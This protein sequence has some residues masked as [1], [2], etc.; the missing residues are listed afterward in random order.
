MLYHHG[1]EMGNGIS[2]KMVQ[3]AAATLGVPVESVYNAETTTS[4]VNN[5]G[6][7][8]ASVTTDVAGPAVLDACQQLRDRLAPIREKLGASATFAQVAEA[9]FEHRIDLTAHGYSKPYDLWF[10]WE[11]GEGVPLAYFVSAAACVSVEIDTLTGAHSVL[12]TDIVLDVGESINPAIDIGQIEGAF[13]Q[14]YG[15]YTLEEMVY[16]TKSG[17][18]LTRGPGNYKIPG[19]GD[20]PREFNVTLLK[21]SPNPKTM[22]AS[23]EPEFKKAPQY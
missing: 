1:I 2:T 22:Y 11:K 4:T 12:S 7:T 6:N 21:D 18:L 20:V 13:M 3:I 17:A 23:N 19:F 5:S 10:D 15:F 9:A 8:C 16:D 14:G